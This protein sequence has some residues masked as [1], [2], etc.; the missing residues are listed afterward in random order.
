MKVIV[1]GATLI[2]SLVSKLAVLLSYLLLMLRLLLSQGPPLGAISCAKA[3]KIDVRGQRTAPSTSIDL[4]LP[5]PHTARS[6][7]ANLLMQICR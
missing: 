2:T 4:Y 3:F 5:H 6:V 7:G 1:S